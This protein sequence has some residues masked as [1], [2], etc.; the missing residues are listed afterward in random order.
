MEA[1]YQYA[2]TT[3][4]G[5]VEESPNPF[6]IRR[7]SVFGNDFLVKFLIKVAL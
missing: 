4:P 1:G 6:E 3:K 7:I 2:F 5:K